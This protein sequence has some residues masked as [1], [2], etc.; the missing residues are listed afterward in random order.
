MV[1]IPPGLD[2]LLAAVAPLA[3]TKPLSVTFQ[4]QVRIHNSLVTVWSCFSFSG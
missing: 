4:T 1:Q 2:S 3:F